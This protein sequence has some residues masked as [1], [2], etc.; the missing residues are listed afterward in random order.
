MKFTIV[1]NQQTGGNQQ[2]NHTKHTQGITSNAHSLQDGRV[3]VRFL[4]PEIRA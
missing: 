4:L 2:S 1:L 3:M